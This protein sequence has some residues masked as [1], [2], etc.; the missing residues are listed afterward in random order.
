MRKK[1]SIR[2]MRKRANQ[3]CANQ[4][5]ENKE[6]GDYLLRIEK[7]IYFDLCFDIIA[8]LICTDA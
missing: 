7:T 5:E 2:N 6:I 8:K 4:E 3:S 1:S